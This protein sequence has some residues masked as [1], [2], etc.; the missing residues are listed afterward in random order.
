MNDST[1]APARGA[2]QEHGRRLVALVVACLVGLVLAASPASAATQNKSFTLDFKG[3]TTKHLFDANPA[4]CD[5]CVPDLFFNDPDRTD[6]EFG[7]G[8][9]AHVGAKLTW[10][11]SAKDDIAY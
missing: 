2:P 7:L 10:E 1:R 9:E 5:A 3:D 8:G 4:V 11:A 6:E